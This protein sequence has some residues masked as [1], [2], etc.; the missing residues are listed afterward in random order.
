MGIVH[1]LKKL[2]KQAQK[3]ECIRAIL[4]V[5]SHARGKARAD[6]DIDVVMICSNPSKL[7]KEINWINQ[8]GE[9]LKFNIENWNMVQSIRTYYKNGT[10]VEFAITSKKW[11]ALPVDAGTKKVISNG[12]KI[13]LDKDHLLK[14]LLNTKK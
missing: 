1:F 2:K 5:G 3:N 9:V 8:F 14:K 6:S 4:L 7:L 11:T 13:I 10:E 12:A